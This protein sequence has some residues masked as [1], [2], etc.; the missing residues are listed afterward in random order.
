MIIGGWS[1]IRKE[2]VPVNRDLSPPDLRNG[3]LNMR[4]LAVSSS[5][6]MERLT[7]EF[8]SHEEAG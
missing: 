7:W 8:G 6:H 4:S 3:Q 1:F 2:G 5:T